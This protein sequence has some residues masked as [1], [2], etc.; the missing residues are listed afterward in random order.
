MSSS[1]RRAALRREPTFLVA[2]FT[3]FA[4][5]YEFL[6]YGAVTNVPFSR[7]RRIAALRKCERKSI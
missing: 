7:P 1:T 4:S 3:A 2:A 5:L 6:W